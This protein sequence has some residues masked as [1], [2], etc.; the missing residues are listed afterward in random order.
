MVN[1]KEGFEITLELN[2]GHEYHFRCFVNG[3]DEPLILPG[4][5][6]S[7]DDIRKYVAEAAASAGIGKRAT[8]RLILPLDEIATNSIV[9]GY[10]RQGLQGSLTLC[11]EVNE[12]Q[13][14]IIFEDEGKMYDERGR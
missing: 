14:H 3:G 6:D 11:S 2:P 7:L 4:T 12:T 8:Y 9:H 1:K 10:E 5:L 13:P